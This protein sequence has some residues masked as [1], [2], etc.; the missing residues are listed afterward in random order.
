M[1]ATEGP[2]GVKIYNLSVGK[3]LPEWLSEKKRRS[4]AK[5]EDYRRRIEI[6]QDFHFNTA[7]QRIRMTRDQQYIIATGEYKP[8][9][10]IFDVAEMSLKTERYL[11][12]E[13]VQFE[14]STSGRSSG[15]ERGQREEQC[16]ATDPALTR[17]LSKPRATHVL[18]SFNAYVHSLSLSRFSR[19]TTRR[20]RSCA[21]T[22]RLSSTPSLESTI[23][24]GSPSLAGTC[25][26]TAR[27]ATSFLALLETIFTG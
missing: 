6:I 2:N 24:R 22:E 12:S 21:L 18:A 8:C 13:I 11:D 16:A 1:K 15:S 25:S 19:T 20:W 3:T 14:V 4:L 23:T 27:P 7:S 9:V 17:T 10:K 5:D 26:T